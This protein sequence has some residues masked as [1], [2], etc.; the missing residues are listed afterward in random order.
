MPVCSIIFLIFI[1]LVNDG[2]HVSNI[3]SLPLIILF[4]IIRFTY[5]INEHEDIVKSQRENNGI[6]YVFWSTPF[7]IRQL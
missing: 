1:V 5:A 4:Y 7:L 3:I 6:T 2:M